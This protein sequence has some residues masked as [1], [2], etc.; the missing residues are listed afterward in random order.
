M[1]VSVS[2]THTYMTAE[3]LRR[4]A[5]RLIARRTAWL[6]DMLSAGGL[7]AG[8]RRAGEECRRRM[9]GPRH[10]S[11]TLDARE[12][13]SGQ[14][15]KRTSTGGACL[16]WWRMGG[17]GE[18]IMWLRYWGSCTLSPVAVTG[19]ESTR[20]G[21]GLVAPVVTATHPRP[22]PDW[23][24]AL[25]PEKSATSSSRPAISEPGQRSSWN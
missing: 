11:T 16:E 24:A 17:G 1:G 13:K 15:Q 22:R 14:R 8:G 21:M 5:C 6:R 25:A 20:P 2:K 4:P 9:A 3:G 12:G 18:R 19:R 10:K 23:P 7:D